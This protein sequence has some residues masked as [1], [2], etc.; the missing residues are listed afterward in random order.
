[1]DRRELQGPVASSS[2]S[3]TPVHYVY[4]YYYY[5]LFMIYIF[6]RS[7][8]LYFFPESRTITIPTT[9]CIQTDAYLRPSC[10]LCE[11]P[12]YT[13]P[14][15]VCAAYNKPQRLRIIFNFNFSR[16]WFI[17]PSPL[18]RVSAHPPQAAFLNYIVVT[19]LVPSLRLS[20]VRPPETTHAYR[21]VL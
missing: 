9:V 1:M 16:Q 2:P 20:S 6:F 19:R 15:P 11:P 13:S 17:A 5:D 3:P 7:L 21:I 14:A 4:N 10:T 18:S 8:L 12:V